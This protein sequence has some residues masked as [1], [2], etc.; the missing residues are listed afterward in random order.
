MLNSLLAAV[1][2]RTNG[3]DEEHFYTVISALQ[4]DLYKGRWTKVC[5][6]PIAA[7]TALPCVVR[8]CVLLLVVA[9]I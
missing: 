1:W 7:Q 5:S 4:A 8:I 9:G 2:E 6:Q 3:F